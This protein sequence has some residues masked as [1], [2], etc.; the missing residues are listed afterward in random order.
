[1]RRMISVAAEN[2]PMGMDDDDAI[3]AS[4][5]ETSTCCPTPEARRAY[6]AIRVPNAPCTPP[7]EVVG[8][9]GAAQGRS[10]S[11][12]TL[13]IQS[14]MDCAMRSLPCQSACGPVCP[15]GVTDVTTMAGF[16]LDRCS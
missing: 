8:S 16:A 3:I 7:M 11:S 2:R 4:W 12:P 15:N 9:P 6:S 5:R 1:M 10:P 14:A 13:N